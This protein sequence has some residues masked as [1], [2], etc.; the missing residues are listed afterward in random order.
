LGELGHLDRLVPLDDAQ[1]N[2]VLLHWWWSP[3]LLVTLASPTPT[4][5]QASGG[6]PPPHFNKTWDNLR[7]RGEHI[8]VS[9][10]GNGEIVETDDVPD[11]VRR[12]A[13]GDWID[14]WIRLQA[15]RVLSYGA[16]GAV[17]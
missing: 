14:A 6:G 15:E 12:E 1:G 17:R 5:W 11:D 8:V 10:E 2:Y 16:T 7:D 13:P 9:I 4:S 3:S